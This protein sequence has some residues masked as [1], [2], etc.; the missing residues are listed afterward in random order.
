MNC[1][2]DSNIRCLQYPIGFLTL[3]LK[4]RISKFGNQ[5]FAAIIM[6]LLVCTVT[7]AKILPL[8]SMSPL[9]NQMNAILAF[10][11]SFS[12]SDPAMEHLCQVHLDNFVKVCNHRDVI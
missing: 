2:R 6:E 12:R 10:D 5:I 4:Y 8:F 3:S 1:R 7:L 9:N 11:L